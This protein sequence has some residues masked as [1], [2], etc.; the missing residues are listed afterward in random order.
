MSVIPASRRILQL[1]LGPTLHSVLLLVL[2]VWHAAHA[3][4]CFLLFPFSCH[5][6]SRSARY[7]HSLLYSRARAAVHACAACGR[8]GALG[9]MP[10]AAVRSV[11]ETVYDTV[12]EAGGSYGRQRTVPGAP[13]FSAAASCASFVCLHVHGSFRPTIARSGGGGNGS[14]S[15]SSSQ[16]S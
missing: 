7:S 10:A 5:R 2:V 6:L 9:V 15:S 4:T 16:S 8:R 3:C 11:H 14:S 12:V 13:N 1:D